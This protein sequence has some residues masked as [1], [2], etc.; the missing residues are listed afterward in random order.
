MG[1]KFGISFSWRRASG[2]S[3]LKGKISRQIG[4]PLT[5]SGRQR[6][7]GRALGCCMA[8]GALLGSVFLCV[9]VLFLVFR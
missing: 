2:L 7:M 4:V 9:G 5:R 3:A 6:K 1:K 8:L